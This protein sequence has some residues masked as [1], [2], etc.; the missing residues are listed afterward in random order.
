MIEF[1]SCRTGGGA[2]TRTWKARRCGGFRE[3]MPGCAPSWPP[4]AVNSG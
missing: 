2:S 1:F 3:M 4:W